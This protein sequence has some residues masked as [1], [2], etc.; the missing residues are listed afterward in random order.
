[1]S[2]AAD[3]LLDPIDIACLVPTRAATVSVMYCLYEKQGIYRNLLL[4]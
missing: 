4:V 3:L 1:M 2:T